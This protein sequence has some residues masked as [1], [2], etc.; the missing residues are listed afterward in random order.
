MQF[1]GELFPG[2]KIICKDS[3]QD[4][5]HKTSSYSTQNQETGQI[6]DAQTFRVLSLSVLPFPT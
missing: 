2:K 1:H 6:K 3:F 5:K 4:V